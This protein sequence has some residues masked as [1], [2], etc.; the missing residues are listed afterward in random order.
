M[1]FKIY[2]ALANAEKSLFERDKDIH[3]LLE[4]EDALYEDLTDAE[5]SLAK[6]D[7]SFIPRIKSEDELKQFASF[8]NFGF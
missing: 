3:N 5:A 4:K 1:I 2:S 6:A 7:M 8:L